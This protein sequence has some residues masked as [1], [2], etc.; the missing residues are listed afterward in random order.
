MSP[1][2][3]SWNLARK[4]RRLG[5]NKADPWPDGAILGKVARK[6]TELQDWPAATAHGEFVHA[7]FMY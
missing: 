2:R 7:E 6:G 4:A 3:S 5:G 1:I